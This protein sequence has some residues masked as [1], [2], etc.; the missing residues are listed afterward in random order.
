MAWKI[1]RWFEDVFPGEQKVYE[2]YSSL[3]DRELVIVS[4]AVLDVALA[5][6][7]S[8]RLIDD[9]KEVEIFLGLDANGMASCGSFGARIRLA[10][11]LGVLDSHDAAV[12][13]SIQ[14]LRNIFAHTARVSFL[15]I[16][17]VSEFKKLHGKF[18]EKQTSIYDEDMPKKGYRD[19]LQ[20]LDT[21]PEASA[22]LILGIF[23]VYQA[24]FHRMHGQIKRIGNAV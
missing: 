20:L 21:T 22:G 7:L 5:E 8:K 9:C 1:E 4:G 3:P 10:L 16:S 17:V 23:A 24:Y 13:R 2:E 12:L 6:L 15:D 11:L 18:G 19:L 14:R